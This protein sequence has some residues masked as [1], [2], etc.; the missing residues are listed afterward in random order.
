MDVIRMLSIDP[1]AYTMGV[2]LSEIDPN[3]RTMRPIHVVTIDMTKLMRGEIQKEMETVYGARAVRM[4]CIEK[5]ITKI[6]EAWQPELVISEAPY[7]GSFAQAYASLVESVSAIRRAVLS[8]D[9]DMRFIQIDPASV[10]KGIGVSGK[11]G[12]KSLMR[13]ALIRQKNLVLDKI[14]I[15]TLD[16]HSVDS[17]AVG[18]TFISTY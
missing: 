17:I 8:H 16:E 18:F 11:S 3:L 4:H 13:P 2:C 5:S 12:D 15:E 6:I 10:K 9:P 7:L 14:N 1:G